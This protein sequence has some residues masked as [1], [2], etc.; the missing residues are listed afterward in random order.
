MSAA[1]QL[2]TYNNLSKSYDPREIVRIPKT[3]DQ[4]NKAV[5]QRYYAFKEAHNGV[6]KIGKSAHLRTPHKD[7][8]EVIMYKYLVK[9]R[10]I[11][12][13]PLW[14][15]S[16][17]VPA[18]YTNR[19]E[20]S[21]LTHGAKRN[22]YNILARLAEANVISV[23]KDITAGGKHN[24]YLITPN[25][26]FV[27]GNIEYQPEINVFT[28]EITVIPERRVWQTLP[29]LNNL[30]NNNN[31]NKAELPLCLNQEKRQE[32]V[33]ENAQAE[34]PV[35]KLII[36][37][38]ENEENCGGGGFED[39]DNFPDAGEL[40]KIKFYGQRT[41]GYDAPKITV[42]AKNPIQN[43]EKTKIVDDFWRYAQKYLFTR[44][45]FDENQL[46]EIKELIKTDVFGS[47]NGS[48]NYNEWRV[49]L[50]MRQAE[51]DLIVANNL[52]YK[53]T[54]YYPL[55][56]FSKNYLKR[57]GFLSA[58]KWTMKERK[59]FTQVQ[60]QELLE[61]AKI[62]ITCGKI[63]RGMSERITNPRE[64]MDY[65]FNRLSKATNDVLIIGD[66]TR[67]ISNISL[68]RAWN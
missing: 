2:N 31:K 67:F 48:D 30:E 49:F 7:M 29:H 43:H 32:K 6:Q 4:L 15:N 25:L 22:V 21:N 45:E 37:E 51:V 5:N 12:N 1:I 27:L 20:L 61:T 13:S 50:M 53:R 39:V 10:S 56:Y 41:K 35:A 59:K 16:A 24:G 58:H 17:E 23:E 28:E 33:Q 38:A 36:C 18:L 62:S 3:L 40:R 26:Y 60:H 66:F 68:T 65:W 55:A 46:K 64:L 44:W 11:S 47:F 54:A 8:F 34:P 14:A 42:L 9:F 19:Q 52:K 63:P 57:G